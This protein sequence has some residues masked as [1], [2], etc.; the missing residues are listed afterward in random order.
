MM[1]AANQGVGMNMG[2]PDVCLTPAAPAPIPVPYPNIGMNAMAMPFVP[3][4]LVSMAPAQNMAAKP[5]MTNGDNAGVAHPLCMQPGGTIVGNPRI[6]IGG[7]PASHLCVPTYGNNFNN[8]LGS[9]TVPSVTNVLLGF[10]AAD[11]W[12]LRSLAGHRWECARG[13]ARVVVPVFALGTATWLEGRLRRLRPGTVHT[14]VLD[15]RGCRGGVLHEACAVWALLTGPLAARLALWVR[16]DGGTASAAE[17]CAAALAE[18]GRARLCGAPSFGKFQAQPFQLALGLRARGAPHR[19]ATPLG[20]S[21]QRLHP[22]RELPP[23]VAAVL[24]AVPGASLAGLVDGG[25]P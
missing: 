1:P 14:L 15:L 5:M 6:L 23:A 18:C 22:A 8:P 13:M 3:N 25:R 12:A 2:F 10:A 11:A 20:R 24:A 7:M 17:W 19:M 4:V 16:I 9:K 21:L